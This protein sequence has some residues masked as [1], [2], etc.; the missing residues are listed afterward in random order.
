M[1]GDQLMYE[2]L[3]VPATPLMAISAHELVYESRPHVK[4]TFDKDDFQTFQVT[5]ND[6]Q[7]MSYQKYEKHIY[8]A[9]ELKVFEHTYYNE[10]I[11]GTYQLVPQENELQVI[12]NGE[13][14]SKMQ[15]IAK[16]IF[17][18]DHSGYLKFQRD[19]VGAITGFTQYDDH[20]HGLRFK[21]CQ[22]NQ[23]DYSQIKKVLHDYIE[24]TANGAPD[25]VRNAFHKDL[26]LYSVK[27]DSLAIWFGKEYINGIKVGKKNS[28]QGK[29]ISMDVEKDAA[30]AKVEI[31]IPG[32][33]V[34][35]DYFL[36]LKI[37]GNW[38]IIHKS[39]T[40]RNASVKS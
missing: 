30:T 23:S 34:F 32:W 18:S 33:R 22:K 31:L 2:R 38:K 7:P 9:A 35:T 10:D 14:I 5:I 19:K 21:I 25:R 29:I 15:P 13:E 39:Y 16:D 24:G 28:R 20:V 36:L 40:W 11:D 3:G 1:D 12:V 8:T 17:T 27:N 37:Q 6:G 4:F 26:N